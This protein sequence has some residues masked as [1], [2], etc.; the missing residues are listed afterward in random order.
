MSMYGD[1]L[2]KL[3]D[4]Q[5]VKIEPGRPVKLRLLDHPHVSLRQF[6]NGDTATRFSWPVW[7]YQQQRVRILEQGKSIFKGIAS[8]I[9]NWPQG[10][11]MPAPFDIVI[12]RTGAGKNDTEYTVSAIPHAGTMP[13]WSK[14]KADMPDMKEKSKGIPLKSIVDGYKPEVVQVGAGTKSPTLAALESGDTLPTDDQVH[15]S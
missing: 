15:T 5:F 7:D 9:E 13:E 1:A 11:T 10:E 4:G 2:N 14:I 12:T 8:A 6:D 3:D